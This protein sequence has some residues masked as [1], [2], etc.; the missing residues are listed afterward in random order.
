M[1]LLYRSWGINAF[2]L[3]GYNGYKEYLARELLQFFSMVHQEKYFIVKE[4]LGKVY[5]WAKPM[6]QSTS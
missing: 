5:G 2:L 6:F 4:E 1:K 3:N